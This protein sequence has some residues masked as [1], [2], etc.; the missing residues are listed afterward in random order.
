MTGPFASGVTIESDQLCVTV[1]PAVGGTITGIRHKASGLSVL[2]TVPWDAVRLPVASLAA[3]DEA[4]WLTRYT[5]GWPLLFPNGGDA[6]MADGTFHGFHGEASIAPWDFR[7]SGHRL[8]LS[9]RFF[10]VPA[11][12]ERE[13]AVEGDLLV[14]RERVRLE[15]PRP[16]S[17]MWGHHPTF[18]SGLLEQPFEIT[19]GGG[20]VSADRTYDPETNPLQPGSSGQWPLIAGKAGPVDLSQPIGPMAALAY[21]HDM[22]QPWIAIRRL[23]NAVAALLSW[24]KALFPCAWLWFELAGTAEAPWFGRARLIGLEPNT[25]MPAAGLAG[26][27]A[28]GGRLLQLVPGEETATV[29]RLH[30]FSPDGR[31]TGTGADGRATAS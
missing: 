6:C 25:T 2:G 4:E 23:D 17:V 24:D 28:G 14:I 3:R 27:R 7:L 10:T 29:L 11:A 12:M 31:I 9:R 22:N 20:R 18:G 13:I 1:A 16:V 30:V 19:C 15:G 8:T 26:A 21:L 5:G